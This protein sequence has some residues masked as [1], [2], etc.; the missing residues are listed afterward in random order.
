MWLSRNFKDCP[1][2]NTQYQTDALDKWEREIKRDFK[3]DD[4]AK[5]T[6][7]VP[8]MDDYP[9]LGVEKGKLIVSGSTVKRLFHPVVDEILKLV[10]G[11]LETV[12]RNGFTV[13][14]IFMAGG[15]GNN[16]YLKDEIATEVGRGIK[17]SK[18]KDW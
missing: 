16:D 11:Q 14:A 18:M 4:K 6:F 3:G 5:Y 15:F 1:D 8:G 17:V 9:E 12:S 7:K 13:K 2:W 10:R